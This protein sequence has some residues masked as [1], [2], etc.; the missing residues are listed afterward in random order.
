MRGRTQDGEGLGLH[1]RELRHVVAVLAQVVLCHSDG[2][3]AAKKKQKD[4]ETRGIGAGLS[5]SGT[6]QFTWQVARRRKRRGVTQGSFSSVAYRSSVCVGTAN[7]RER[8]ASTQSSE[9]W[10]GARQE[11]RNKNWLG[12]C[13]YRPSAGASQRQ[14]K[15]RERS[16]NTN[17][18]NVK[19]SLGTE[20][21]RSDAHEQMRTAH[22]KQGQ[23]QQATTQQGTAGQTQGNTGNV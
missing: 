7:K 11:P 4:D 9:E 2:R 1:E 21:R 15:D 12:R 22:G 16:A 8:G 20:R 14:C 5:R 3:K 18:A 10:E 17:H 13:A 19:D 6:Q 23:T